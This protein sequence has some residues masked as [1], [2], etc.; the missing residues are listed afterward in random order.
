MSNLVR[1]VAGG[2]FAV[3]GILLLIF[4]PNGIPGSKAQTPTGSYSTDWKATKFLSIYTGGLRVNYSNTSS[5][6]WMAIGPAEW[7]VD[8]YDGTGPGR[9]LLARET[10][11]TKTPDCYRTDNCRPNGSN[12]GAFIYGIVSEND[13]GSYKNMTIEKKDWNDPLLWD[14]TSVNP[15]FQGPSAVGETN[16]SDNI[17]G[18]YVPGAYGWFAGTV[19]ECNGCRSYTTAAGVMIPAQ[20]TVTGELY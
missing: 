13:M 11:T 14:V 8:Y 1:V 3:V 19:T 7:K 10:W 18:F 9:T 20:W 16:Q 12:A 5:R 4:S 2:L 17:E 15:R 6:K